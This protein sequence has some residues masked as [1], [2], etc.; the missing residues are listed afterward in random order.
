MDLFYCN[1]LVSLVRLIPGGVQCGRA[2]LAFHVIFFVVWSMQ[3]VCRQSDVFE[4]TPVRICTVRH[5]TFTPL[6][7][8]RSSPLLY[9]HAVGVSPGGAALPSLLP[10]TSTGVARPPSD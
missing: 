9:L 2:H 5:P 1:R 7:P 6:A 10:L 4:D 8:L 3:L